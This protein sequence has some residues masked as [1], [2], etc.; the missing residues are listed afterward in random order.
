MLRRQNIELLRFDN[1]LHRRYIAWNPGYRQSSRLRVHCLLHLDSGPYIQKRG[2]ASNAEK[3]LLIGLAHDRIIWLGMQY[4]ERGWI[5][6]DEYENLHDY[7]F[8]PYSEAGGNGSAAKVMKDVDNLPVHK[9]GYKSKE[10]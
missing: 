8:I 1:K 9:T 2:D 4:I 5:S 6:Q 7:L 3:R 10:R